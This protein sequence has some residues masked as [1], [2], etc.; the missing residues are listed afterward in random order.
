MS[1]YPQKKTGT[2][3]P[4]LLAPTSSSSFCWINNIGRGDKTEETRSSFSFLFY[5]N[6]GGVQDAGQ[7]TRIWEVGTQ[8]KK[9]KKVVMGRS[10]TTTII[11]SPISL[12]SDQWRECLSSFP[13]RNIRRP[14][15]AL[16]KNKKRKKTTPSK[17]SFLRGDLY[18]PLWI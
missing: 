11:I 17:F 18:C 12:P 14:S 15:F 8:K 16:L 2:I 3:V 7:K 6:E 13:E 9:K 4:L 10:T 5:W 1:S